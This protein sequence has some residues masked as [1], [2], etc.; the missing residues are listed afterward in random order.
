MQNSS[1]FCRSQ[2]A[3]EEI[4][5]AESALPNVK[6][7]ATRAAAAWG[8]EALVA[9]RWEGRQAKRQMEAGLILAAAADRTLSENPDRG[10]ADHA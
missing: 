10:F 5:A 2:Q 7:I 1:V 9:Q 4:R 3:R 6:S 8:M